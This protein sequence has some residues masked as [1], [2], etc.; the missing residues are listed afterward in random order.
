MNMRKPLATLALAGALAVGYAGVAGAQTTTPTTPS[1]PT[2]QGQHHLNCDAA[3]DR[4]AKLEKRDDEVKA[5]I[6]K[7]E[8]RRD[9][10]VAEG[11]TDQAA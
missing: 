6:A 1:A 3:K 11:K 4:F 8:A 5:R 10:L 9:K 2:T 7:A